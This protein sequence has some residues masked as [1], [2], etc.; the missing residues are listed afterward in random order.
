MTSIF[1][2]SHHDSENNNNN[3]HRLKSENILK[4]L[5]DESLKRAVTV[6]ISQLDDNFRNP[7]DV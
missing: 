1:D 3:S 2:Y 7:I 6:E 4:R 5:Q